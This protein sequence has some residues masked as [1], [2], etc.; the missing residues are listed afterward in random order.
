MFERE[1]FAQ[2]FKFN[3]ID[4]FQFLFCTDNLY[5]R[6][7]DHVHFSILCFDVLKYIVN[8]TQELVIYTGQEIWKYIYSKIRISIHSSFAL[9]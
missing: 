7:L 6:E 8:L 5:V 3:S 9:K 1:E 2:H 4:L